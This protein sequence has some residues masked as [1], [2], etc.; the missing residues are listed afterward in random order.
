[1]WPFK[2]LRD[3]I[4]ELEDEIAGFGAEL[5]FLNTIKMPVPGGVV[6]RIALLTRE[7]GAAQ[8]KLRRLI[9]REAKA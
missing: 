7:L 6:E 5:D 3:Q 1:M 9:K 8:S 2:S 4:G